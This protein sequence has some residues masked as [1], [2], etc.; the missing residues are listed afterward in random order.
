MKP[1]RF[2]Y[3]RA[4][5]IDEALAWLAEGSDPK[6]LA[7]G[8]SL[9][10]LMNM[11][12]ARPSVLVDVNPIPE[13]ATISVYPES[14]PKRSEES[15]H[16]S[17]SE[18]SEES[19]L[20]AEILR[21]AGSPL[22]DMSISALRLGAMVRHT[23]LIESAVVSEWAP[24][25]VAAARHVGH[26]A[27]RN[28]GTLGG[29]LAHAD[30][31][32]ELPAAV[33]ALGG[34]IV[35][36]GPNSGR[37]SMPAEDLFVGPFLT[38]LLPT[39]LLCEIRVP[40]QRGSSWG[41]AE[42]A[43]RPGDFAIAGVAGSVRQEAGVCQSAR[44]VGFGVGDGPVRLVWAERLLDGQ[45]IDAEVAR[46]AGEA[47]A[48]AISAPPADVHASSDYRRHLISV[49]TEQVLLEAKCRSKSD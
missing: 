49:L 8:Q 46:R 23:D 24:L 29:S 5:S 36:A 13:L 48:E 4:G 14:Y 22:N 47:A 18:R 3:R 12:L 31:A 2:T 39:E 33:V 16:E 10:P 17:H 20:R 7:G 35:A 25:L 38:A 34:E 37:R 32:A 19:H 30:P 45:P 1:A 27:I 9:V 43:R 42:L 41:F 40:D 11:R 21:L 6:V 15:H 28:M 26:R 44:L